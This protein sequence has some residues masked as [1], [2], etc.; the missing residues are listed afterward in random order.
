MQELIT[1]KDTLEQKN[2]P[3]FDIIN[4]Q[5]LNIV[6]SAMTLFFFSRK[7]VVSSSGSQPLECYVLKQSMLENLSLNFF[8]KSF[9]GQVT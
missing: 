3:Y 5:N 2:Y 6:S 9:F 4:M 1:N 8:K 7:N